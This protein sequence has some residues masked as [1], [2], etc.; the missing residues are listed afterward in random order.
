MYISNKDTLEWVTS[1]S[2]IYPRKDQIHLCLKK[3]CI[4]IKG[5]FIIADVDMDAQSEN[6]AIHTSHVQKQRILVL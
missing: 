2:H 4:N 3:A 6:M 5:S 1:Q